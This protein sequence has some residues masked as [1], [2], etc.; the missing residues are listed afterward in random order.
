MQS[1]LSTQTRGF[2]SCLRLH[3][4]L[5]ADSLSIDGLPML[6]NPSVSVSLQNS[7]YPRGCKYYR[8]YGISTHGFDSCLRLPII[9]IKSF[10]WAT[11]HECM[12]DTS[13]LC[14][15]HLIFQNKK[16]WT[17][18]GCGHALFA[19]S[20]SRQLAGRKHPQVQKQL[21]QTILISP[22]TCALPISRRLALIPFRNTP[23]LDSP[24]PIKKKF[25]N[26]TD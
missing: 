18:N 8:F 10:L 4:F 6:E 14:H 3:I 24:V 11:P 21:F 7:P 16:A 25:E 22:Y 9:P 17:W 26:D 12:I 20:C 13:H 15:C 5:H 19:N 2:D 23:V 1:D